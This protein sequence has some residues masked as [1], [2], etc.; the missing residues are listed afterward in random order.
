MT[1]QVAEAIDDEDLEVRGSLAAAL[2]NRGQSSPGARAGL[3]RLVEDPAPDIRLLALEALK[4]MP[5]PMPATVPGVRKILRAEASTRGERIAAIEILAYLNV[6]AAPAVPELKHLMGDADPVLRTKAAWALMNIGPPAAL[7]VP[8]LR[9]ALPG[10][11]GYERIYIAWGLARILPDQPPNLDAL[12]AEL[13]GDNVDNAIMALRAFINLGPRS[14]PALETITA[15][16][17]HPDSGVREWAGDALGRIGPAAQPAVKDLI[18]ALADEVPAVRKWS[19]FGLGRIGPAAAEATSDLVRLLDDESVDV[20]EEAIVALGKIKAPAEVI[21]ALLRVARDRGEPPLLR[22]T[23]EAVPPLLPPGDIPDSGEIEE[24]LFHAAG[25]PGP[26]EVRA[27]LEAARRIAVNRPRFAASL[28]GRLADPEPDRRTAALAMLGA[29]GETA[30]PAVSDIIPWLEDG[31]VA[32]EAFRALDAIAQGNRELLEEIADL[33]TAR[34]ETAAE[35]G[36]LLL[37]RGRCRAELGSLKSAGEDLESAAQALPDRILVQYYRALVLV[38]QND[39][40]AWAALCRDLAS[41][42]ID[43]AD[44]ALALWTCLLAQ[45]PQDG[46]RIPAVGAAPVDFFAF[47]N[48]QT[49]AKLFAGILRYRRGEFAQAITELTTVSKDYQQAL[50][51]AEN[52]DEAA[53]A[54]LFLAAASHRAGRPA[55]ANQVLEDADRR[56]LEADR[57][58]PLRRFPG[59]N[60]WEW[61]VLRA[62]V[63]RLV[64]P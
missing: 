32:P 52:A 4:K 49:A 1:L 2:V 37:C 61:K 31:A 18:K 33:C 45:P 54:L 55:D 41:R 27:S 16:L 10:A 62:E 51:A 7:A 56:R 38:L 47:S 42:D 5:V 30:T 57:D 14:V 12:T 36:W 25:Q 19:A 58:R 8:E 59:R 3:V 9:A 40:G 35:K 29:L 26:P 39:H 60:P 20:C 34:L 24:L 6:E 44:R 11:S 43:P 21:P 50:N 48:P 28:R 46:L 63:R 23:L 17:K 64:Q 15:A 53:F 22:R 13:A